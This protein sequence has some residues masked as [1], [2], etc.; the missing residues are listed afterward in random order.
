MKPVVVIGYGNPLR[1]DDGL[2]EQAA[3]LLRLRYPEERVIVL[4]PVQLTPDLAEPLSRASLAL[5]IDARV[6]PTGRSE[7][8]KL[9]CERVEPA[10][11]TTPAAF[12]HQCTPS[13]LLT[14]AELLYGAH[15]EAYLLSVTATQ[16]EVMGQ[17]SAAV[18]ASLPPLLERASELIAMQQGEK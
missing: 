16:F 1:G 6:D 3:A 10:A 13:M 18:N 14:L 2:G 5:F 15:P 11:S 9:F 8:G 4:S 12:S 7:P 17:L